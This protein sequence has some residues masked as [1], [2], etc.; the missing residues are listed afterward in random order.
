MY[1]FNILKKWLNMQNDN[2]KMYKRHIRG[3]YSTHDIKNG[4]YILVIPS[5]YIIQYSDIKDDYLENK[6]K[7]TNSDIAKYL[8]LESI[9]PKSFYK[10]Y[11]D[12]MPSDINEY[13]FFYKKSELNQLKKTS[14][15]CKDAYNFD[16]QKK[17]I[18]YDAKIIYKYLYKKN[19]ITMD[20]KEFY[21]LFLKFR[22]LVC[23]RV[24]GYIKN[25]SEENAM[26]PYA[27]LFNHSNNSNTKWYFDDKKDSFIL[28]ATKNI[29]KGSEIYDSYGS[30]SNIQLLRYYSFTIPNNKH[31]FV[32]INHKGHVYHFDKDSKVTDLDLIKKIKDKIIEMKKDLKGGSITNEN[33]VNIYN[34]E[35]NI[36][37][38][39]LS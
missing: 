33:I 15:F 38:S 7:N 29:K 22:V 13:P 30:K 8:L 25:Y 1:K 31:S 37:N 26:V 6:L 9:N 39:I 20:F 4:D 36:F 11:L 32:N 5:K 35:I 34:D 3:I 16:E 28:E 10:P 23:S 19:I 27:D 17:H 14:L 24:F 18:L 21:A 12:S 2:L